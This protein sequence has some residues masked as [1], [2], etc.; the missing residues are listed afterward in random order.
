MTWA[1]RRYT[2]PMQ[3]LI[4]PPKAECFQSQRYRMYR[5]NHLVLETSQTMPNIPFGDHFTVE[6]RWDITQLSGAASECRVQSCVSVPFSKATWWRKV[7]CLPLHLHRHVCL[8]FHTCALVGR[9]AVA[10]G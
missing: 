5:D 7:S 4:G 10:A 1:S 3:A 2:C 6:V 8:C 9:S